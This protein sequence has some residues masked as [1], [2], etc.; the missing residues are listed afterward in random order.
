MQLEI[1]TSTKLNSND[2]DATDDD[3]N[4]NNSIMIIIQRKLF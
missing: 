3:G 4:N 1:S 2:I